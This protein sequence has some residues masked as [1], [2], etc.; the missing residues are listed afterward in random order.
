MLASGYSKQAIALL[1]KALAHTLIAALGPDHRDTLACSIDHV[2]ALTIA[3]QAARA[4]SISPGT[5]RAVP[6]SRAEGGP[7]PR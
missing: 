4:I 5:V 3:C 6:G 1:T 2:A 7:R